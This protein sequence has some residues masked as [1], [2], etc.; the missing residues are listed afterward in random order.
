MSKVKIV[1]NPLYK[2]MIPFLESIPEQFDTTGELLYD[3]RNKVRRYKKDNLRLV[4]KRYKH[5]LFF[6]R[7]DYTFIRP[8]KAKRAYLY[9]LKLQELHINTPEAI[10]YLEQK[11]KGLFTTGYF[12]SL[13]CNDP[14][15]RILRK[16]PFDKHLADTLASF[17]VAMHQKG[18]LHGDL[19]LSNILY[20]PTN[21]GGYCFTV[22]DTNRSKFKEE[23]T[24]EECLE[25]LKRLSHQREL[26]IYLVQK[27]AEVRQWNQEECVK[28][29]LNKLRQFERK[30]N[31]IRFLKGKK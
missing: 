17:L 15:T 22:I 10:A 28:E 18:F 9:A 29:V 21:E 30:R 2:N 8:S 24:R 12:V 19:N 13:N 27:Y 11:E 4:V 6:Q 20:H 1:T 26:L 23:P 14:D 5:P 7:F 16:Q 25:N 3:E 31:F